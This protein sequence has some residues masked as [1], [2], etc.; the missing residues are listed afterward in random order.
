MIKETSLKQVHVDG[1]S[2]RLQFSRPVESRI[3]EPRP[4]TGVGDSMDFGASLGV[5]PSSRHLSSPQ[6]LGSVTWALHTPWNRAVKTVTLATPWAVRTW[7]RWCLGG[8]PGPFLLG[9]QQWRALHW[10]GFLCE[11]GR[12][13]GTG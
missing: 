6:D 4:G 9:T 5:R 2:R 1:H 3:P 11:L 7:G 10:L 13:H 12:L 8:M